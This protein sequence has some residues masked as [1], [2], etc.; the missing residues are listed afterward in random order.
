MAPIRKVILAQAVLRQNL[1]ASPPVD[2]EKDTPNRR[3]V[4]PASA[5]RIVAIAEVGRPHHRYKRRAA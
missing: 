1:I 3:S 4:Q 5:G 2:L